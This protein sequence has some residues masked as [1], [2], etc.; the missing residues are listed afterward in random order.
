MTID[1][2]FLSTRNEMAVNVADLERTAGSHDEAIQFLVAAIRLRP[3]H[4]ATASDSSKKP[5]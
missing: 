4:A 2:Q 3:R 1:W 5:V